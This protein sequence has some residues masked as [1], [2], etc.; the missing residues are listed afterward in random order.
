MGVPFLLDE[1]A[2]R[3]GIE[4]W[5]SVD[6]L[7]SPHVL[8]NGRTS[9]GKT[10]AAKLLI[11]RTILLAPPEMQPVHLTV[12]DP[13]EDIDFSF[14]CGLPHFFKGETSPR[15]F[16][17]FFEGYLARKEGRDLSTNLK[18]LFCDEFASLINLIEDKKE[19]EATQRKLSLLLMLSRSRRFSVQMATQ[20]PSAQIFGTAGSGSREQFGVVCLLGNSG[21]ETRKMLFDGDSRERIEDFGS[22][23]SRGIG[24]LSINGS[25]A[26]PVRVPLV[27]NM[28]KLDRVIY[29]CL[30]HQTV[31]RPPCEA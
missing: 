7:V 3:M 5:I 23:G 14:L 15:G 16:D 4:R 2:Y 10:V 25:I 17:L 8:W 19:R 13:K 6:Y 30:V 24:W 1:A 9:S 31:H 21:S 18:I 12:L 27:T 22:I 29:N 20:Q 11:A 28:E 26:Q